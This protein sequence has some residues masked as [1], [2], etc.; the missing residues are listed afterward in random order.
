MNQTLMYSVSTVTYA[1]MGIAA[2]NKA[3]LRAYMERDRKGKEGCGF[4]IAVRADSP[5]VVQSI[6]ARAGVPVRRL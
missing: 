2:L 4:V 5:A 3:G 6:L 1:Q